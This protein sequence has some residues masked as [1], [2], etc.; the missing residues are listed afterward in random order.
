MVVIGLICAL[1]SSHY[2][3][4][5]MGVAALGVA[6]FAPAEDSPEWKEK[7]NLLKKANCYFKLGIVFGIL[8]AVVST[9]GTI[10]SP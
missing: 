8:G 5:V 10:K 7:E 9:W 6:V 3:A 4:K 1:M 2:N